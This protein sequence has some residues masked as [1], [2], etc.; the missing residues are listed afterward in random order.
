M[1]S[2]LHSAQ[3]TEDVQKGSKKR[4]HDGDSKEAKNKKRKQLDGHADADQVDQVTSR[5]D[6]KEKKHKKDRKSSQE[7]ASVE[8]AQVNTAPS[9]N[10]VIESL[11][12]VKKDKKT[13]RK[14][15]EDTDAVVAP[16]ERSVTES[17][18][19]PKKEKRK[20]K[21]KEVEDEAMK[22]EAP[23]DMGDIGIPDAPSIVQ[24]VDEPAVE[25]TTRQTQTFEAVLSDQLDSKVATSFYSTRTSL[26]LPIPPVGLGNPMP[27]VLSLHL[28]PLLLTYFSPA[29]G[30][31]LSYHEPVLSA[32][33]EAGV[34]KA[35]LPPSS[36]QTLGH[37]PDGTFL[38]V[39]EE[40][41]VCWAWLTVTFLVFK[42]APGDELKGWT[43]V[44]SEGFIGVVCYNYF[45]AAVS[46]NRIPK[47]WTWSGDSSQGR[48]Q[49]KTPRKGKLND[50]DEPSQETVADSQEAMVVQEDDTLDDSAGTFLDESGSKVPDTITI[51]VA[52]L[53]VVPAADRGKW[54]LQIEGSLLDDDAEAEVRE[55][56][57]QRYE[58]RMSKHKSRSRTGTPMMSGGLPTHSRARSVVSTP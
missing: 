7:A 35:L 40:L 10:G 51:R 21:S 27:A 23:L 15:A 55:E 18:S 48:R 28:A 50:S 3:T 33:P 43:N 29:G 54:S 2:S 38:K 37:E 42:P 36:A 24:E 1:S 8:T 31:V 34:N 5:S 13:K 9:L 14:Q 25:E 53:E 41:G 30:V 44:M 32:R 16:M 45:Q 46:K 39:G 49:R 4:K 57:R 6:K 58:S 19:S 47:T 17:I 56:E 52:D 20:R 22:L 11:P 12:V 26:Y